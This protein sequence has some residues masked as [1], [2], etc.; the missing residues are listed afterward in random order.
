MGNSLSQWTAMKAKADQAEAAYQRS[1]GALQA[2]MND[3][4][5]HWGVSS[6]EEAEEKLEELREEVAELEAQADKALEKFKQ[7]WAKWEN[8]S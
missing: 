6:V 3:L 8:R 5:E 2:L 7:A 1:Q 4:R